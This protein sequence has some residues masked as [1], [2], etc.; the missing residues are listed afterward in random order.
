MNGDVQSIEAV[1]RLERGS[2]HDSRPLSACS[3]ESLGRAE[4]VGSRQRKHFEDVLL[5]RVGRHL[6][7]P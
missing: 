7:I 6:D 4:G 3:I 1:L 2:G 5:H